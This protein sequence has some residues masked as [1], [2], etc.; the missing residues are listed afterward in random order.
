MRSVLT[1][2]LLLGSVVTAQDSPSKPLDLYLVAGQSNSVGFDA[3]PADLVPDPLDEQVLFWFRC[4]DPP[5]DEFDSRSTNW[6]HLHPQPRGNPDTRGVQQRQYGNFKF[7]EGGFG[8][9][10]GFARAIREH[11]GSRKFGIIKASFSGTSLINDWDPTD[12]GSKGACYQSLVSE[13]RTAVQEAEKQGYDCHLKG[14]IWVQG[15]SDAGLEARKPYGTAMVN[16]LAALRQDLQA[17]DLWALLGVNTRFLSEKAISPT[18]QQVIDGQKDAAEE[19]DHCLYVDCDGASLA[20][21]VHFDT[22]GTLDIGRRFAAAYLQREALKGRRVSRVLIIGI[23]GCRPDALQAAKTPYLDDLVSHGTLFEGTEIR[24]ARNADEADTVSG[25]G[26]S[27]LL[28]GVWPDKHNVLNNSFKEPHYEKFPHFFARLREARPE[29]VT[30]SFSDWKPISELIV[31]AASVNRHFEPQGSDYTGSDADAAK[32]ACE[33]LLAAS[34][35]AVVLYLGQVD[36][37]GHAH[38]FHPSVP[39][40]IAAIERV[41]GH[42]GEVTAAIHSRPQ[43]AQED[44]LILVCTDHGGQGTGH[45]GGHQIEEIRRTFLIVSGSS[46]QIGHSTDQTYQVDVVA[47]ALTHLG[48]DL[49]PEWQL[50]GRAVGLKT[51]KQATSAE[52][53]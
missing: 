25:P 10:I 14:M 1:T 35:D 6:T 21:N 16:M 37:T 20:N 50:D 29:A 43:Y 19:D 39:E 47:T 46:A 28:T 44:W 9:E 5:P 34:P 40:Y 51:L 49:K 31:S 8:P 13:V 41:D 52:V 42:I 32:A 26:W 27:N 33:Y 24:S 3:N 30:A 11:Q 36:E 18:M 7:A 38:G 48:I 4:G 45:G 15:E 53:Q 2:L 22:A 17:P 23:D 12:P